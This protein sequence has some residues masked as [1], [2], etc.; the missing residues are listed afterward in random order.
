MN[1]GPEQKSSRRAHRWARVRP[2]SS[3][4]GDLVLLSVHHAG[5]SSYPDRVLHVLHVLAQVGAPDGD[6]GASI[7]RPSQWLHL[8]Q[9][10]HCS[11]PLTC[12]SLVA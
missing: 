9:E 8:L 5:H 3:P 12:R 6:T 10:K 7:Y 4:A 1:S 11:L 2:T